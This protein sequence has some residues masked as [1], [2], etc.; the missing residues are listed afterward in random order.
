[1]EMLGPHAAAALNIFLTFVWI[2]VIEQSI[3]SHKHTYGAPQMY[4]LSGSDVGQQVETWTIQ[5][6]VVAATAD[7]IQIWTQCPDV[8]SAQIIREN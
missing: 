5:E 6:F 7:D 4:S 8:S 3:S 1:M 2:V